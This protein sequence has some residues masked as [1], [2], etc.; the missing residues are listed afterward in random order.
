MRPA[1]QAF[2]LIGLSAGDP[3]P[4]WAQEGKTGPPQFQLDREA[5][6]VVRLDAGGKIAWSTR[7]DRPLDPQGGA[8]LAWDE[9]RVYVPL[10]RGVMALDATTGKPL[11]H[12]IGPSNNLLVSGRL[13]LALGRQAG[14]SWFVGRGAAT[15]VRA[16]QVKLPADRFGDVSLWSA[17]EFAGLFL[18]RR[19]GGGGE[20]QALLLDRQGDVRHRFR[21]PVVAAS[22]QGQEGVFLSGGEVVGSSAGRVGRWATPLASPEAIANGRLLGVGPG[23][24]LAFV[25]CPI[26]DSG[27]Q[28]VRFDAAKGKVAWRARCA[29]LGVDHSKYRH[30]AAVAVGRDRVRVTSK[31]SSGTFV[32]VLDLKTG[33]RLERTS[34]TR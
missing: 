15:G 1:W 12:A 25:Y 33:K 6:R 2:L 26:A 27:V 29:P 17:R 30:Q 31:G 10:Q 21:H 28:L 4:L 9:W 19:V 13:V 18:V 3:G 14:A 8:D 23:Q 5:G 20:E 7:L 24:L 34:S 32:E 16:W 22:T 11:W